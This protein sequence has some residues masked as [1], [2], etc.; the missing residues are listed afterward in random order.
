MDQQALQ[1]TA[2]A[3]ETAQQLHEEGLVLMK[4]KH[5]ADALSCFEQV[6][7]FD[8]NHAEAWFRIGCCRSE[9][10]KQK[11]E[12]TEE[13]LYVD[14]EFELYE[15]AIEAYQKAIE[16]QPDHSD[17]RM[18]LGTLF[19]DF[20]VRGFESGM[21]DVYD[22]NRVIEWF[23]Q[24][25]KVNPDLIDAYYQ[26]GLTYTCLMEDFANDAKYEIDDLQI[27]DGMCFTGIVGIADA[28]IETYQKLTEIQPN[29]ARA[30]YELGNAYSSWIHPF[31]T[32]CEEFGNETRDEIEAMK[33]GRD[34]GIRD[35]LDKAIRAYCKAVEIEPEYTDAYNDLAKVYFWH[36]DFGKAIRA[37]K[38]AFV[39][40]KFTSRETGTSTSYEIGAGFYSHLLASA[41]HN[42]GKQNFAEENYTEAIECYHNAIV[43]DP[44]Y[45]EVYY[46]LA[47]AN[48][49]AGNYELAILWY[50]RARSTHANLCHDAGHYE[51]V[52]NGCARIE[53]SYEY[54]DFHYRLGKAYH[55]ISNYQDAVKA[56]ETAI[57]RQIA[58][59]EEYNQ[60]S[61]YER[62]D[63]EP[64]PGREWWTKVNQNLESAS[65]NEP[66]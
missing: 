40:V 3:P 6:V 8:A 20:G 2:G 46:D 43:T 1:K 11:I 13:T 59:E 14:G 66:L 21:C 47:L 39:L 17:A 10:A 48:D 61:Y 33:Q 25:A 45:N 36:G 62:Y 30:Y 58:I 50:Q 49:E 28:R 42:L 41:Y 55:R 57:N 37:L 38:Q 26:L 7:E 60:K 35:I 65:R 4:H 53:D 22:Y 54:P 56:Y 44:K 16:L 5:Y 12:G 9:L 18:S 23:K 29:D 34:P 51:S 64:P 31:I 63:S 24:A 32:I 15:G 19:Y 52:I 27:S